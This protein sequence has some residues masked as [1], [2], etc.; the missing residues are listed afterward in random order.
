MGN[1]WLIDLVKDTWECPSCEEQFEIERPNRPHY[2]PNPNCSNGKGFEALSGPWIYFDGKN[3]VPM[4]LAKDMMGDYHFATHEQSEELYIYREGIYEPKGETSVKKMAQERLEALTKNHYVS[5]TVEAVRRANYT[6]PRKFNNPNDSLV[7]KNGLLDI[8]ERNLEEH[9]PEH[10]HLTKINAKYDPDK[11]CP[12]IKEFISDIVHD[13]DIKLVQEMFGYCLLPEYPIAEAFMLLGSGANGKS[14]LLK[15]LEIF[16]GEENVAGPSLQ[17]LLGDRFS[18]IEL[19]GKLANIHADL[20]SSTLEETGTFKMLTG[21]DLIQGE[22]K[23][24]DPIKFHN[25]AKLIYS[26]NE[27]PKTTD[28]TEA[29]FRRWVIIEFP[30]QFMEN[31]EKT[32]TELPQSIVDEDELSGLLN[33]ALDGLDRILEDG[34]FSNT[35]SRD[36]IE[37][38]WIMETDSLRAFLDIATQTET[39]AWTAKPDFYSL[40]KA[41]CNHHNLYVVK[42]A[43]VTKRIPTL[44]PAVDLYRPEIQGERVRC[45]RNLK[46]KESFIKENSYV[47]DVPTIHTVSKTEQKKNLIYEKGSETD[48]DISDTEGGKQEKIEDLENPTCDVCEEEMGLEKEAE[49]KVNMDGDEKWLCRECLM[50]RGFES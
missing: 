41:F 27:L 14:T 8:R 18:R 37:Q 39:D 49:R 15:L 3:F 47:Q 42:K 30:Y 25:H 34:N 19:Y 22:K 46:I 2:C 43:Q 9:S 29:F 16:L 32:D 48:R 24:Q 38:K 10:V 31:D 44:K 4:R 5:E 40:Y 50:A 28:R 11:D 45:W 17:K 36:A 35:E 12:K 26:A 13:S 23:Y 33:W 1:G 6:P 7:V 21:G 20:S